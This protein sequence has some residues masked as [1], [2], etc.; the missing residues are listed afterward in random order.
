MAEARVTRKLAAILAADVVGF[1]RLMEADEEATVSTLS[2]YREIIERLVAS[3]HGRVFGSAGDS[4]IAEFAS[5]VEAVRCAVDIQRDLEAH[6]VDLPE[7]RRMRLRIG[8]NLGDVIVEGDNLL[9]DGVNIAARL[10]TL[11][12]PGGIFLARPVFDQIKKQLDLGYEYLGEHEV[13]NIAEPVRVYRVLIEP[14][15]AGKVIGETKHAPQSWKRVALAA[16]VVVLIGVAGAVT[17]LRPWEPTIKPASVE[18][19]A[20]PLPEKPSIAVLPFANIS[21]DSKQE[22]L[23]DG[24]T[25]N[26]ITALSSVSQMFVI[27]RNSVFT[28]KGKPVKVQ[29]VAEQL[30]VRYVLEGGVQRSGDKVRITAQLIDAING[31][32]LWSE[33]YDRDVKDIFALQ[34]EIT[35]NILTALQ[36][37]L[38][39]G[40]QAR[41]RRVGTDVLEASLLATQSRSYMR[42]FTKEDNVRARELAQKAVELDPDYVGAYIPLAWTHLLDAQAGWAESP[43]EAFKRAVELVQQALKLD[44]TNPDIYVILGIIHLNLSQH[45]RAIAYGEKAVALGPNLSGAAANLAMTLNYSGHPNRAI[46]LLNKAMRLSPYY[47]DWFLGE[48]GRALYLTEQYDEA[49]NALKQR[50]QRNPKSSEAHVLLAAAYGASGR[51]EEA[52]TA[53]AEFLKPRPYY[54]LKHYARGEFYKNPEDLKRVLEGLRKAG[55]PE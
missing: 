41:A 25:E 6:N 4:V 39:E 47:P 20:F 5:P 42:R 7:D 10:E 8:V 40:E 3:H 2:T 23:V 35:L 55:M 17:W 37:E 9:G 14:E 28:F 51:H 1:S 48:L 11:A 24:I 29:Q 33:R 12:D 31:H 54:T 36:V 34:D 53:L 26:I 49:I 21:G 16:A 38:T 44:D 18:R 27:A 52:E 15:A 45:D 46:V 19:M 50:L 13:K 32:Y 22:F 30:G 43:A